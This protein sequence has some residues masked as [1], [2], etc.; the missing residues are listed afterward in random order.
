[1]EARDP[2]LLMV[3]TEDWYF[4]SHR[5]PLAIAARDRG[6]RVTVA[7][8]PGDRGEEIRAA[9]LKHVVFPLE[10]RNLHP[11]R[12]LATLHALTR[13]MRRERPG[14]VHLVAL[15]PIM[16]G[17]VAAAL[18]GRPPVLSAI[19]GLGYVYLGEGMARRLMRATYESVFRG[20]VRPRIDARVL[21]QNTDDA[22]LLRKRGLVRP[23][24]LLIVT[25]SGVDIERFTP[26]P[27]PPGPPIVVLMHSRML[28]EKGVGELVS[29]A[30]M[31]RDRN[32]PAFVVR[33]V[34]EPDPHNPASIE[35]EQLERWSK[36]GAVEWLGRR[37]DIPAELRE[38]H[39]A[40]LPS[41]REGAPLS[42]LEA[43]A[44]G[45]PIVTSDV[46]GCRAVVSSEENGILVPARNAE[47]LAAALERLIRDPLLRKR[48]GARGR[49]RAEAEFSTSI[50]NERIVATYFGMLGRSPPA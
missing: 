35:R 33:L 30:R 3:V 32:V 46:P 31:M 49:Q 22:D 29:A 28:W 36:E 23:D 12:E 1:M 24:Q 40:C 11:G 48:F 21:V 17:N 34:G 45:R 7:T 39:I 19:A 10:R 26:T 2:S 41:Y 43:A 47:A 4:L 6:L 37:T 50:V 16:Y 44:A 5:L 13:V 18:S 9:G 42:L 27:E 15:K 20:F 25:G 14:V 38:S 8:G